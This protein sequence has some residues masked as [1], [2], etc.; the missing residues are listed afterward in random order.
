MCNNNLDPQVATH[1]GISEPQNLNTL[2]FKA[3]NIK[4][5]LAIKKIHNL[6]GEKAIGQVRKA[7]QWPPL[8]KQA[9]GQPMAEQ[10][11]KQKDEGQ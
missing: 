3:S 11:V 10:N 4:M 1:V 9:Q 7:I 2:V 8:S 6:R 5:Q